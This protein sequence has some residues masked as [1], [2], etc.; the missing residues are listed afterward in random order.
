M[1]DSAT[2]ASLN[3]Y[4]DDIIIM[5]EMPLELEAVT[6]LKRILR[7]LKGNI[8]VLDIPNHTWVVLTEPGFS[9]G[10]NVYMKK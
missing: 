5:P 7:L 2:V 3:E 10:Y 6:P 1:A 8:L 4:S 9:V